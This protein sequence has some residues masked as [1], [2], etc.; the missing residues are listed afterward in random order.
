MSKNYVVAAKINP[1]RF[2]DKVSKGDAE[3]YVVDFTPWQEDNSPVTT[4]TWTLES[5]SAGISNQSLV[6]GVASALISFND[7]GTQVISVL[8]NTGTQKKKVWFEIFAHDL[9]FIA[10]D[11]GVNI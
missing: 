7:A 2:S 10:N 11:Y 9:D 5:G 1:T 6:S 8:A 3:T 4:V